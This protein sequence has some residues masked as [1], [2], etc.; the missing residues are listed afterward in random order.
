MIDQVLPTVA[1]VRPSSSSVIDLE[2][3]VIRILDLHAIERTVTFSGARVL[4][5][6]CLP[7]LSERHPSAGSTTELTVAVGRVF[8]DLGARVFIGDSPELLPRRVERIW[9]ITGLEDH[10]RREGL[11]LINFERAG[12]YAVDMGKKL[13]FLARPA[14]EAD[15]IVSIA[16]C[17]AAE[18][19]ARRGAI[20]NM[21]GVVP[22]FRKHVYLQRPDRLES[23]A[24]ALIDI[25]SA[26]SPTLTIMELPAC[27]GFSTDGGEDATT[28]L[29]GS[30]DPVALDI[31][32]ASGCDDL[33]LPVSIVRYAAEAGLGVPSPELWDV[34]GDPLPYRKVT[35]PKRTNDPLN[36]L[37]SL[38]SCED[39]LEALPEFNS[40]QCHGCGEC[41]SRCPAEALEFSRARG[42]PQIQM[43]SCVGCW[44]C[45]E[46]CPR[47]AVK[48][49]EVSKM[50]S[51]RNSCVS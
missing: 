10:A 49:R 39:T 32:T 15:I 36:G 7:Q 46:H 8:R 11:T 20:G 41:V 2:S 14:I 5:K 4:V 1:S 27:K 44:T 12:A 34:V 51:R 30:A 3:A 9:S 48:V 18:P 6:P 40:G 38:N 25:Y 26:V 16:A 21:L 17:H 28:H 50:K 37:K 42:R 43:N 35:P 22:G 13:Y 45:L 47:G 31:L 24:Q 33:R 29:V 23:L 19:A